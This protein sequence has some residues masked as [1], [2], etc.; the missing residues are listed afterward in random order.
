[1]HGA[2]AR[3][4]GQISLA[5]RTEGSV[6]AAVGV[7]ANQYRVHYVRCGRLRISGN[8]DLPVRL[9]RD[10]T[11]F[12]GRHHEIGRKG[13]CR[14]ARHPSLL[15]KE[16]STAMTGGGAHHHDIVRWSHGYI[17]N[18]QASTLAIG[19]FTLAAEG[20]DAIDQGVQ[21]RRALC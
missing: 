19:E 16:K 18:V 2:Q 6:E 8:E 14:N 15:D 10:R 7:V 4:Q 20:V 17:V 1:M 3:P 9:N 13:E 21:R 12:S 11:K 5:V